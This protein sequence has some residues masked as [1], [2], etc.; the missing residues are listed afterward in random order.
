MEDLKNIL[1]TNIDLKGLKK[2]YK[3]S[4][5]KIKEEIQ[6]LESQGRLTNGFFKRFMERETQSLSEEYYQENREKVLDLLLEGKT[7]HQIRQELN[8]GW[9]GV[10]DIKNRIIEEKAFSDELYGVNIVE[11]L[12]QWQRG[13]SIKEMERQKISYRRRLR[14]C[15]D[16]LIK[17][18]WINPR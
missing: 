11:F 9:N 15:R 17:N 7:V 10:N 18:K 3:T 6:K 1:L 12:H 2:H 13:M 8:L 4:G 16:W 14:K 5:K